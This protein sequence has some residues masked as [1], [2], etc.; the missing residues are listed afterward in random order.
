MEKRVIYSFLFDG[1]KLDAFSFPKVDYV[2][3]DIFW[4]L[5]NKEYKK[6]GGVYIIKIN[7]KTYKLYK[8]FNKMM[9]DEYID[10][11]LIKRR[12]YR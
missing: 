11:K 9:L 8:K 7:T 4:A 2:L 12:W 3:S 1:L 5:K 10:N 6:V